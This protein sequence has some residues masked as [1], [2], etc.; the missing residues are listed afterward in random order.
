M[1]EISEEETAGAQ[2]RTPQM[3]RFGMNIILS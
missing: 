1:C 3:G 2:G